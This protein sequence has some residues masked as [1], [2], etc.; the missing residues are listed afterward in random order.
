MEIKTNTYYKMNKWRKH[1]HTH[2]K[3]SNSHIKYM[4]LN[5]TKPN[6]ENKKN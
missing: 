4:P 5:K 1:K 6:K 3:V 2:T